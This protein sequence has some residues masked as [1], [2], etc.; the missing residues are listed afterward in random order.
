MY[1]YILHSS[2]TCTLL[3][4]QSTKKKKHTFFSS[5]HLSSSP[6]G[7]SHPIPIQSNQSHACESLPVF[8]SPAFPLPPSFPSLTKEP[9]RMLML[10]MQKKPPTPCRD[11]RPRRAKP[12][13]EPSH[14]IWTAIRKPLK[15]LL[16]KAKNKKRKRPFLVL[17][18]K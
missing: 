5:H 10:H 7:R 1:V 4:G 9:L 14:N 16:E 17:Y 18:K 11:R 3:D 6:N 2:H 13:L 15:M 12:Q 8:D